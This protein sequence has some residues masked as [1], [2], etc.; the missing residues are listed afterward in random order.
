MRIMDRLIARHVLAALALAW[1]VLVG[2]DLVIYASGQLLRLERLGVGLRPFLEH[3]VWTV[4]RRAYELFPS[5]ALLG[6]VLG[7]GQLAARSELIAMRAAGVSKLRIAASVLGTL[8]VLLGAVVLIGETVAV[9]GERRAQ[10]VLLR[11]GGGGLELVD[12]GLWAREGRDFLNARAAL[13]EAEEG[14]R[15]REVMLLRLD[16]QARLSELWT[17]QAATW[18]EGAWVL[19]GVR[20][21]LFSD[22]RL[23][24]RREASLVWHS[25]LD[26]HLLRLGAIRPRYMPVSELRAQIEYFERNELDAAEYRVAL[27]GRVFY[28][29]NVFAMC[30]CALPFAFASPRGAGFGRNLF[31]GIVLGVGFWLAQRALV[32]LS[33]VYGF[34]LAAASMLPALV[35]G[36]AGLASLRRAR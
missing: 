11:A 16:E 10:A 15:L 9:S 21:I 30:L 35:F 25:E 32:N 6:S 2:L 33:Q 8:G 36:L 1:L 19:Q 7:L 20:R 4:P 34:D 23:E 31:F 13:L 17:A 27:W 14:I 28:P 24:E 18:R 22:D 12:A 5:A 29:L 26:P 3:I